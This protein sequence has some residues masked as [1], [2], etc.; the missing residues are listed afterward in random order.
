MVINI[1]VPGIGLSGGMRVLFQYGE[2]FKA[3]GHD[4]VFYTPL[5]AYDVQ[6]SN[7]LILNKAHVVTNTIKRIYSYK[8]KKK[9]KNLQFD[10][11]VLPVPFVSD[12]YI[13]NAD[14]CM[15]SAW[16]T[17]FSVARLSPNK[18]KKVYL[19]QEYGIMKNLEENHTHNLCDI[20]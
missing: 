16:P 6:N 12:R 2:L 14:V 20:L 8:I 11:K 15:A 5:M 10:V 1:I 3:K 4:V 18:G 19:I 7:S 17:A 9:Y 13:R